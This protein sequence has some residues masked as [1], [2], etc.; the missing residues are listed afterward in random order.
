VRVLTHVSPKF[1]TCGV[2]VAKFRVLGFL[3]NDDSMGK[4]GEIISIVS[5]KI[6]EI[7]SD[8]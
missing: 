5:D 1:V 2:T 7:I 6:C 3:C 8:A 4:S